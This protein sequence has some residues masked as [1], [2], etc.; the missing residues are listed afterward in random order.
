MEPPPKPNIPEDFDGRPVPPLAREQKEILVGLNIFLVFAFRFQDQFT[1]F[2]C[3][4]FN[5][6]IMISF[7]GVQ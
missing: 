6:F 5:D 1:R 4:I 7:Q 2:V 3:E